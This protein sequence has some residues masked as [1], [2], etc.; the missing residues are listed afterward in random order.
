MRL[1][2]D[3]DGTITQKDTIEELAQ[4]AINRKRQ[5]SEHNLQPAWDHAVKQYIQDYESYKLNYT[6]SELERGSIEEE[7]QFLAGLKPVEEASLTRVSDS[8]LFAGLK[9]ED[10]VQMGVEGV[11]SGR[12]KLT[13]GF[14]ELLEAA[15]QKGADVNVVS[16]NWSSAFVQGVLH[17]RG[18]ADIVANNISEDG[19]IYGPSPSTSRLTTASDKMDALCGTGG[20][21]RQVLYF[22]DSTTDITCLLQFNGVVLAKEKEKSSLLKTLARIGVDVPHVGNIHSHATKKLFWARD[23]REVLRSGIADM[24]S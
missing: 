23:F 11:S 12:I 21:D 3:F 7:K 8:G 10:L 9:R 5:Q 19:Q 4:S 18:I 22:G 20:R 24:L 13:D 2:F 16:V 14:E 1:V 6:P 17:G 15:K